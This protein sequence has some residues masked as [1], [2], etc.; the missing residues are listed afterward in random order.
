M[1]AE[2]LSGCYYDGGSDSSGLKVWRCF[3]PIGISG[4]CATT[5]SLPLNIYFFQRILRFVTHLRLEFR[6]PAE[7]RRG[8]VQFDSPVKVRLGWYNQRKRERKLVGTSVKQMST[9]L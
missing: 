2:F 1:S 4:V 8:Y 9:V 7:C 3:S 6:Q 5:Y